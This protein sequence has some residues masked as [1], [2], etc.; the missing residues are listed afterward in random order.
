[1]IAAKRRA[2]LSLSGYERD[3]VALS[4][5]GQGFDDVSGVSGL[6]C[7]RDARS[8]AALADL[9][10][11][12]DLD[13]VRRPSTGAGTE[14]ALLLYRN[15]SGGNVAGDGGAWLRVTLVGTTCDRD[16]LGATVRVK[17]RHG[18]HAATRAA[19]S[20]FAAQWDPRVHFGL[21]DAETVEWIEVTWPGGAKERFEGVPTRSAW[22]AV[23]G[24]GRL[25]ALD[26]PAL[27][28]P[29]GG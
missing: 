7:L 27:A 12:G 6:D 1:M 15:D 20:G 14:P 21:G 26:A 16:A 25:E 8:G 4:R 3:L 11:D 28:V 9:D 22:R 23:Q 5:A 29:M 24:S 17:S 19:G 13:V 10:N 2:G 18:V